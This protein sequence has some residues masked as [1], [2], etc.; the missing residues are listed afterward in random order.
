MA[1]QSFDDFLSQIVGVKEFHAT[2]VVSQ[3]QVARWNLAL[4]FASASLEFSTPSGQ[5]I[6]NLHPVNENRDYKFE[7]RLEESE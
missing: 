5:L 2:A 6:I 1:T 7:L 4:P 3:Q